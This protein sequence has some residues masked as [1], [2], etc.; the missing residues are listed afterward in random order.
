[1]DTGSRRGGGGGGFTSGNSPGAIHRGAILRGGGGGGNSP[2]TGIHTLRYTTDICEV[3]C[4]FILSFIG[5]LSWDFLSWGVLSGGFC[6]VF[7]CL[8]PTYNRVNDMFRFILYPPYK[9]IFMN[10]CLY[11]P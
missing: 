11:W 1:M 4:I 5:V 10:V 2:R 3:L 9:Y 7:F 8:H 6:L